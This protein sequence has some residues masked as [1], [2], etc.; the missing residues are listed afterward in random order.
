MDRIDIIEL[1]N[2]QALK[3]IIMSIGK[4]Q[5]FDL[6]GC[7]DLIM[8]RALW[9]IQGFLFATSITTKTTTATIT[10]QNRTRRWMHECM[11]EWMSEWTD[12]WMNEW[13]TEWLNGWTR[14]NDWMTDWLTEWMNERTHE[15]MKA[16]M[17]D[18]IWKRIW[19]WKKNMNMKMHMYKN[20]WMNM[21]MAERKWTNMN[22]RSGHGCKGFACLDEQYVENTAPAFTPTTPIKTVTK[23]HARSETKPN[24]CPKRAK[25]YA[26]SGLCRSVW[27]KAV[28]C[29]GAFVKKPLSVEL[30]CVKASL[31]KSFC[32]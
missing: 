28:L 17:H 31:C 16:W 12:G 25:M 11:N 6:P 30:L 24:L 7:S 5:G 22:E 14:L 19:K 10:Q 8:W 32:L 27:V 2:R 21:T 1:L 18:W 26:R 9:K 29:K 3:K 20:E 4:R 13:M 15:R 23:F